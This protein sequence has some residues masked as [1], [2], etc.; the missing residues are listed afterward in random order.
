MPVM[1]NAAAM[2]RTIVAVGVLA[3]R[4]DQT[5]DIDAGRPIVILD[6]R[7]D[8]DDPA[9]GEAAYRAGHIPGAIYVHLERDLSG[10]IDSSGR[11]GRH[12]LP[13]P[14]AMSVT[15]SRLGIGA[16]TQVVAYDD[17]SGHYAARLWWM[18]RYMGHE[19]VAVLDGGWP[20]WRSTGMPVET[21]DGPI[22]T[23]RL[24]VGAP[25]TE[26]QV[27]IDEVDNLPLLVDSRTPDRYHGEIE[28]IDPVAGHIPAALNR[29]YGDNWTADGKWRPPQDLLAEFMELLG[30]TP[31]EKATFY[32][33]SGVRACINILA[34]VHAGLPEGRLYVGSWSEWSRTEGR[35]VARP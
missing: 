25:R 33:G 11:G 34:M 3:N 19:A 29:P 16:D 6:C 24:F 22:S 31:P 26:R 21:G 1:S 17:G 8:L 28:P 5:P 30:D 20:A 35:P 12:P 27:I 9:A 10:P 13:A 32:C 7:F 14:V 15:F 2:E 18:L 4:V 23:P